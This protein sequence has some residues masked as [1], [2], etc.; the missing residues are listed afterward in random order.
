MPNIGVPRV[1]VFDVNETLADLT[2]LSER[3]EAAGAPAELLATWFASTLR[4]GFAL[5]AAGAYAD[6]P[7]VAVGA[8]STLLADIPT[9]RDHAPEAAEGVVA[10]FAELP[11]HGDVRDAMTRLREAGIRIVTLTNGNA[12]TTEA[13]LRRGGVDQM[14]EQRLS[15]SEIGRW[16]P[17]I[18][19]YRFAAERCGSPPEDLAL[20]AVHPWDIDGAKRAGLLGAWLNRGSGPYPGV[21]QQPDVSAADLPALVDRLLGA[22]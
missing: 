16:K 17:A 19:A 11:L 15:V 18:E 8:L 3:L 5:T 7:A 14:V 4:D 6:F 13:L 9:L 10:G 20:V 2:P 21:F 22:P 12:E 1:V